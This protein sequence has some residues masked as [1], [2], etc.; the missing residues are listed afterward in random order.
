MVC[1]MAEEALEVSHSK[2]SPFKFTKANMSCVCR[3]LGWQWPTSRS[4]RSRYAATKSMPLA[5][6]PM[7]LRNIPST[8]AAQVFY[9]LAENIIRINSKLGLEAFAEDILHDLTSSEFMDHKS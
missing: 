8:T 7:G 9:V 2:E 6:M 5:H 1:R 3:A 4:K